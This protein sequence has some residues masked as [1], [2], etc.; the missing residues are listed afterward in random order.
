MESRTKLNSLEQLLVQIPPH[1]I[2]SN[3][4]SFGH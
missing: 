2:S 4:K 1:K 3:R